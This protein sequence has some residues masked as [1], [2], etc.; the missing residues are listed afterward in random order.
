MVAT[1]ADTLYHAIVE[2]YFQYRFYRLISIELLATLRQYLVFAGVAEVLSWLI[3]WVAGVATKRVERGRSASATLRLYLFGA[4]L[5]ADWI[6][7]QAW[8]PTNPGSPAGRKWNAIV[9]GALAVLGIAILAL[10]LSE[11]WQRGVA[12]IAKTKV[13]RSALVLVFA[14]S[15]LLVLAGWVSGG[16]AGAG[17]PLIIVSMDTLRWDHVGALGNESGISPNMDAL[18]ADGVLFE[19][20]VAQASWTLPSHMSLFTGQFPSRHGMVDKS[21]KFHKRQ[22]VLLAKV[23]R[24]SGYRTAAFT[25]GGFV[26]E[27]YGFGRGFERFD[28]GPTGWFPEA[29]REWL[30]TVESEPFF[31]FVQNYGIHA[32]W[33]PDELMRQAGITIRPELSS[34]GQFHPLLKEYQRIPLTE[35]VRGDQLAHLT[36]RYRV[37]VRHLDAE[38]GKLIGW[39]KE[40][41]RYD[42]AMIVVLSDHGEEFGEHGH[43]FHAHSLYDELIRVPLIVKYPEGR[44]KGE[45]IEEPVQLIDVF[46]SVLEQ[47]QI[48]APP[49]ARV[50][51]RLLA[52]APAGDH[53]PAYA[54]L[55]K[56]G[57]GCSV[58]AGNMKL[59]YRPAYEDRPEGRFQLFDIAEDP[60]EQHDLSGT[61]HPDADRLKILLF[62]WMRDQ[63]AGRLMQ[64]SRQEREVSGRLREELS[65]LG[66]ID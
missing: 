42:E 8:F 17:N 43:T 57:G 66:Y 18:A 34:F 52:D 64:A 35:A 9:A 19:H 39:L 28:L 40:S 11:R 46:P 38:L 37:A 41:R 21:A 44:R 56:Y 4:I 27:E 30:R 22:A 29:I 60:Q 2:N 47:L 50:D 20:A 65:A 33:A 26:R 5:F 54:E 51:G 36:D 55:Y 12:A 31:L 58:R 23:L 13:A 15:A 32:Y 25:N 62:D 3:G 59:I 45:V 6:N 48:S 61:Y 10:S 49:T 63:Q 7:N 53:A 14:A 24:E 16:R 1:L